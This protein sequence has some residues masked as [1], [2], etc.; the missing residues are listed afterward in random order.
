MADR[1]LR[2]HQRAAAQGNPESEAHWFADLARRGV[3][4]V[5]PCKGAGSQP[6]GY[7][8]IG[9]VLPSGHV[10]T[11]PLAPHTPCNGTG[12]SRLPWDSDKGLW[13]LLAYAGSQ[14]ARLRMG[15]RWPIF[16]LDPLLNT[17]A[18]WH[19]HVLVVAA[20]AAARAVAEQCECHDDCGCSVDPWIGEHE[21]GAHGC[22]PC[23]A[24][25]AAWHY[26]VEP[27]RENREACAIPPGSGLPE[28]AW[29]TSREICHGAAAGGMARAYAPDA[30]RS[31]ALEIGETAVRKAICV[32]IT[33]WATGEEK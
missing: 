14:G 9:T 24:A 23:D 8:S 15:K 22:L 1:T 25:E 12:L 29:G 4:G 32:G 31:A 28:W 33:Q 30:I 10:V 6:C 11:K 19:D 26:A 13:P 17:F 18:H 2:Q 16:A 5:V 3:G 21:Q 27:T 7:Q 20:A